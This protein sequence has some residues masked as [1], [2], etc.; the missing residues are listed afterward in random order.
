MDQKI[1]VRINGISKVLNRSKTLASLLHQLNLE[2]KHIAVAVNDSIIP[3][4]ERENRT[5]NDGDQ[6]EIIRAVAGG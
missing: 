4:E 3:R 6:I 2:A 5:L 1:A